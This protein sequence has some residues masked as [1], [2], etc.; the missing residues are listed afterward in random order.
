MEN[1]VPFEKR[2]Y[3]SVQRGEGMH[4]NRATSRGIAELAASRLQNLAWRIC[5][6]IADSLSADGQKEVET[7]LAVLSER[8]RSSIEGKQFASFTALLDAASNEVRQALSDFGECLLCKVLAAM[9]SCGYDKAMNALQLGTRSVLA[10]TEIN[11]AV[12]CLGGQ[13]G[14]ALRW[15][16]FLGLSS[17]ELAK[18]LGIDKDHCRDRLTRATELVRRCT[19]APSPSWNRVQDPIRQISRA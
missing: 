11:T 16:W 1:G 10:W 18:I 19:G 14:T 5:R 6:P 8:V 4:V 9:G 12:T 15:R 17:E 13:E 2:T 3:G 7:L